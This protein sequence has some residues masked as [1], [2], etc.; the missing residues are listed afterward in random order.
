[1]EPSTCT[2]LTVGLVPYHIQK[3]YPARRVRTITIRALFWTLDI[4]THWQP[5][6][7]RRRVRSQ[8]RT[9]WTL[10]IPLIERLRDAVWA[11]VARLRGSDT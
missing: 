11:A 3:R 4:R 9:A 10:H 8:C 5:C 7:D 1:M 2:W 6:R